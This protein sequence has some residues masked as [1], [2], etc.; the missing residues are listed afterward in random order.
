MKGGVEKQSCKKAMIAQCGLMFEY[1]LIYFHDLVV[2]ITVRLWE[3]LW[4]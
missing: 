3:K 2:S 1:V 4:F